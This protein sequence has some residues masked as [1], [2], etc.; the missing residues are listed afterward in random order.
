MWLQA[1]EHLG[2]REQTRETQTLDALGGGPGPAHTLSWA[3][4]P[5]DPRE[6]EALL[7]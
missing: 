3:F 7:R 2:H 1:K 4:Q 5:W 6:D